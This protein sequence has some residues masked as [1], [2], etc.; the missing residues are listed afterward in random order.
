[1]KQLIEAFKSARKIEL[2]LI[3]AAV[4]V[5]MLLGFGVS[6]PQERTMTED[7]KRMQRIL[8]KIE[9]AGKVET[10]IRVDADC[11]PMGALIVASGAENIR[12][13]LKLQQ[14]V[15]TL[16]GLELDRIEIVKSN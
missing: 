3:A 7:E 11:R 4:C 14:A 5:L 13:M 16:T 8:S 12:T 6:F 2:I 9:G 10:M 1:M 15:H